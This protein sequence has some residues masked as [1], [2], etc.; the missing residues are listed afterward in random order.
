MKKNINKAAVSLILLSS[1]LAACAGTDSQ[2][3]NNTVEVKDCVIQERIPGSKATGAFMNM[4]KTGTDK[5]SLIGAKIPSITPHV[6]I[7]KMTMNNGA[8]KMQQIKEFPLEKGKNVFAKGGFHVMLMNLEKAVNVGEQHEITLLFNDGSN[9]KCTATVKSVES[10]M[11]K[12]KKH[13]KHMKD[14]KDMK[15]MNN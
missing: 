1:A 15:D 10:L 9:Q 2:S 13:M 12:N 14:M 8:M 11:P 4:Y 5:I 3:V 7:H 6:E